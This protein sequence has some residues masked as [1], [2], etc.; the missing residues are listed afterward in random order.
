MFFKS[1]AS[2][3]LN[4]LQLQHQAQ[5]KSLLASLLASAWV[6][7]ARDPYTGGHLWRVAMF[8]ARLA[9]ALGESPFQVNRIAMAGFLHDLGKIGIPDAILRKPDKLTDAEYAVI[10]THP[11]IGARLI[12]N[13]PFSPLVLNAIV[14]HHEMPNGRGYPDGLRSDEITLEAKI[15]AISDAFDAMTSSRPYRKGMPIEKALNIIESELGQQ[16]DQRCGE[17]FVRLGRASEFDHIVSHS[18]EGIPLGHCMMCGPTLVRV[19]NAHAG[20]TL[21]CPNCCGEYQW[22]TGE[23][24][25]LTAKPTGQTASAEALAPKADELQIESLIGQWENVLAL[26]NQ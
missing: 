4:Q 25:E 7:E 19:R 22:E 3:Q 18:D 17:V 15:V 21:A 14:G 16:F 2:Q 12:A 24:G 20:D 6:V 23:N 10:K 8:S 9:A 5:Q 1:R 11:R 26:I 13:H